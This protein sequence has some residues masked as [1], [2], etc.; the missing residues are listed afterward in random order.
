MDSVP[1]WSPKA[2]STEMRQF[3]T[4]LRH[5]QGQTVWPHTSMK[6]YNS[7]IAKLDRKRMNEITKL[8]NIGHHHDQTKQQP[9]L[10]PTNCNRDCKHYGHHG[11][12]C[13]RC[14]VKLYVHLFMNPMHF[15]AVVM[16][17]IATIPEIP[18]HTTI[19]GDV[20]AMDRIATASTHIRPQFEALVG[21]E[22]FQ[23]HKLLKPARQQTQETMIRKL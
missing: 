14:G 5:F 1:P 21:K 13:G 19:A 15:D 2:I 16:Q 3:Q 10:Y 8:N 22:F 20:V 18:Y 11:V 4:Q 17:S 7:N 12:D 23:Y 6:A 9:R